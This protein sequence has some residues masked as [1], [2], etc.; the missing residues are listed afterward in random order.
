MARG[1]FFAQGPNYYYI[2][3]EYSSKS[4]HIIDM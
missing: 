1:H 2:H 3:G 4:T